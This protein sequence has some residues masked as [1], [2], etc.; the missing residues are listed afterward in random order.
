MA[1]QR[2]VAARAA[3]VAVLVVGAI[4]LAG[5]PAHAAT[6]TVAIISPS[7]P[8]LVV[9]NPPPGCR[10]L[11]PGVAPDSVVHNLTNSQIAL[12]SGTGCFGTGWI[13]SPGGSAAFAPGSIY[14]YS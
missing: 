12:Y 9:R 8:D 3:V 14:V 1:L 11:G 7:G 5:G 13:V 6:G 4:G 10:T 2:K